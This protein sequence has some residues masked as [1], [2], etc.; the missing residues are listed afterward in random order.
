MGEIAKRCKDTPWVGGYDLLNEPVHGDGKA[1]R[2][3]QRRMR[4]KIRLHD[5]KRILLLMEIGGQGHLKTLNLLSMIIWPG[6]FTIIHG[7]F[8]KYDYSNC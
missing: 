6:H 8:S 5:N 4:D 1:V 7:W 2:E 3:I